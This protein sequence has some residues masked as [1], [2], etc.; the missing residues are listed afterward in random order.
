[1]SINGL[2]EPWNF[3]ILPSPGATPLAILGIAP[4]TYIL[5]GGTSA[6]ILSPTTVQ[7]D[8]TFTTQNLGNYLSFTSAFNTVSYVP[9][10]AILSSSV[11]SV[12]VPLIVTDPLN[13]SIPWTETR[14]LGVTLQTSKQTNGHSYFVATSG[15]QNALGQPFNPSVSFVAIA[16]RPSIVGVT[17]LD[18][19]QILV[20]FSEDMRLDEDLTDPSH[21]S[22]GGPTNV[23][24]INIEAQSPTQITLYTSG[25]GAGSYIL[26]V[27]A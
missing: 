8:A 17:L 25:L 19:G 24:I 3:T 20:T 7:L 23:T 6:K 5:R 11:V 14:V 2:L 13:G 21:Y 26:A 1:M 4:I 16:T 18:E 10:V 12:G 22:I 15:L 9:I 27:G